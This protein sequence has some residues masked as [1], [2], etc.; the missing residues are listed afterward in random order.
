MKKSMNSSKT[1]C[2][3]LH[4]PNLYS[5][6][7]YSAKFFVNII[8]MGIFSMANELSKNNFYPEI[9]NLGVEKVIDSDFD[10]SKYI[11]DNRIN[12]VGL[13]LHWH[14]QT[15]DTLLVAKEIKKENPNV[16]IFLG[17][18]TSSAYAYEILKE[19]SYIDTVIKGEG[20]KPIVE[21]VRKINNGKFDFSGIPNLYWRDNNKI[22]KNK[23]IWFADENE[24]NSYSF[25]GFDF[26]KNAE[27]YL[28]FPIF[29]NYNLEQPKKLD[30]NKDYSVVCC[31]GRGCPGNCTWC[32]GGFEA[33]KH[34]TGRDK[35]IL[36]DIN[37]VANEI[38]SFKEKYGNISFYFCFDPYPNKQEYLVELF[39]LLGK[40]MPKQI[41]IKFECF[42]LPTKAFIDALYENLSSDSEIIISPEFGDEQMRHRHKAFYF[43][44]IE[45]ENCIKYMSDK[46]IKIVLYFAELPNESEISKFKTN[47]LMSKLVAYKIKTSVQ[48]FYQPILDIEP[49]SPWALNPEEYG[50][51]K[52]ELNLKTYFN[53]SRAIRDFL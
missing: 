44:N 7:M 11:K 28:K 42:S 46:K 23:E 25:N 40:K 9:I 33:T 18:I 14:Y 41:A 27:T 37:I 13:S 12:L 35:V 32:G 20:E 52:K 6:D 15:Y 19:H 43:S 29:Y 53:H 49:Y 24:L 47:Q 30:L 48:L 39:N 45:L 31:L 17:G 26:L 34:I 3:F 5:H 8:A 38:I 51:P 4:V 10:I 36:R 1:D 2:L 16:H 50:M 21:L 22:I